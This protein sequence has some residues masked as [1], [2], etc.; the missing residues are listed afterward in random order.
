MLRKRRTVAEQRQGFP[1]FRGGLGWL[2]GNGELPSSLLVPL[3]CP[4]PECNWMGRAFFREKSNCFT[5]FILSCQGPVLRFA[6]T[7]GVTIRLLAGN[8]RFLL[9]SSKTTFCI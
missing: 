8:P 3:F 9:Q 1:I 2:L 7:H 5:I 6:D 4:H